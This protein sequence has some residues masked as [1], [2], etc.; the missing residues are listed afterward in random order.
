MTST[1]EPYLSCLHLHKETEQRDK[2]ENPSFTSL[3]VLIALFVVF[4]QEFAATVYFLA[5]KAN[6]SFQQ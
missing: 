5:G 4:H 1:G 6:D 3:S 2:R